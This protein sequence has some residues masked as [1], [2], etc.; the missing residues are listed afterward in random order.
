MRRLIFDTEGDGLLPE[1]TKCHCIAA[2]DPD[3]G[4]RLNW[5]PE[6]IDDGL[7]TLA[8]A[9]QLW[10]HHGLGYDFPM[11]RKTKGF[12]VPREKQR[13]T[14]VAA[15]LMYP[16]IKGS[17]TKRGKRLG[18]LPKL[19]GRHTIEAWGYRLGVH[20]ASFDGPW[21]RWSPEMHDYMIQ[22]V[23]T[24]LALWEHLDLD[25]YSQTAIELEHRVAWLV[26]QMEEWGC[27]F[28][29]EGAQGFHARL[30][31]LQSDLRDQ[32]VAEFGFWYEPERKHGMVVEFTPKV[33]NKRL[34]YTPGQPLVKLKQ[35]W[36]NPSSRAHAIKKLRE[37][38]WE[39]TE[40]T[41]GGQPKLTDEVLEIIM[42]RFP[43]AKKLADYLLIEKRLG[44]LAEG[45]KA[46]LQKV[47]KDGLMHGSIN[48]MGTPHGRASHYDPNMAQVPAAKKPYGKECRG[49]FGTKHKKGLKGEWVQIGADMSGLQQRALAHYLFPMDGGAY[50]PVATGDPHWAYSQALGLIP[51]GTQRNKK[52]EF[53]ETV[54]EAGGKRFGYAYLFGCRDP[55]AGS[56]VRD[57]CIALRNKNPEWGFLYDQ[58]FG[59]GQSN[60]DVGASVRGVFDERLKLDK[61]NAKLTGW[62]N[63]KHKW[64]G[65][66]P[67]LDGRWVPCRM[68]ER[69]NSK[70]RRRVLECTSALNYALSSA[71]AIL[72]KTWITDAFDEL[73]SRGFKPGWDGDFVFMLWVHDELQ[74]ACRKE[75]A[76]EVGSV[77]TECAKKAGIKLKFRVPVASEYKIGQTWADCH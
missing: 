17:D 73:V 41:E 54:R 75:I 74:A 3:T 15:R 59:K 28:D 64:K 1:V 13:D 60:K 9:D 70:L 30:V 5:K 65:H 47:D 43:A 71:E 42:D 37:V 68:E 58:F 56:I 10:A 4:E 20:K 50:E 76:E 18:M 7:A 72:C 52:D 53:H 27:P 39:P 31:G 19:Y 25:N 48:P 11:L 36:F 23:E 26:R 62:L 12:V 24:N 57:C 32:L 33:I 51:E 35:T 61:L 14:L 67:G 2:V 49:L 38:G 8:S 21:D 69:W 16:D 29:V 77:L 44:M 22:D 55:M 45:D 40:F 34:G 6:E 66:I 46:W 63:K